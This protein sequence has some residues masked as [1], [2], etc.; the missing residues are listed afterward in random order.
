MSVGGIVVENVE[1]VVQN[2][3]PGGYLLGM[4]FLQKCGMQFA[5]GIMKL[6]GRGGGASGSANASSGNMN[7]SGGSSRATGGAHGGGGS[8]GP[9]FAGAPTQQ[10]PRANVGVGS[11]SAKPEVRVGVDVATRGADPFID[12]LNDAVVNLSPAAKQKMIDT[13]TL[14]KDVLEQIKTETK[15]G[16]KT[17]EDRTKQIMQEI[18]VEQDK[19]AKIAAELAAKKKRVE[20]YYICGVCGREG[21]PVLPIKYTREV[22]DTGATTNRR[23]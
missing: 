16:Q 22:Q 11:E 4:S 23:G 20:T 18:K 6:T 13:G 17:I 14:P 1:A 21:C 15:Q 19:Q 5:A 3:C 8:G 2:N 10:Q 9:R 12:A 7:A